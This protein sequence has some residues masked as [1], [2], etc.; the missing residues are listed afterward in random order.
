MQ[1]GKWFDNFIFLVLEN[2]G[3]SQVQN[4]QFIKYLNENGAVFT[5][6]HR[7]THPSGPNYRVMLSGQSWSNNEFDGV[8][9]ENISKHIDYVVS[10]YRGI[11]AERHNPF[12]DMNPKTYQ[13]NK[14]VSGLIGPCA[15]LVYLGMDDENDAHS[16]SLD[17]ADK[18][19]M[20]AINFFT[21]QVSVVSPRTLFMVTTD[22]GFGLDYIFNHV[23]T[24]FLG[25]GIK[26]GQKINS[27]LSHY[28]LARFLADNWEVELPPESDPQCQTYAGRSLL[29][30]E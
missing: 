11:P 2:Q 25:V 22:E 4:C 19:I 6:W 15:S 18:N 28:N 8:E 20:D 24:G 23:F 1:K 21:K 14:E 10:N 30:L 12:K 17:I 9:R 27:S 29:E 16:G 13:T 7:A 5:K 3:W 26:A